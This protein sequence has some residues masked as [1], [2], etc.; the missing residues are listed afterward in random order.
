MTDTTTAPPKL[1]P[2][3]FKH[4]FWR[5]HRVLHRLS[6]GR[7]LWTPAAKRG[8]GALRLTTTGRRSGQPRTVIIGYIEDGPNLVT[9]AMNGWDEGHPAWW[10][11]LEADP[12]ATV[13]LAHEQPRPVRARA[14]SGAERDRLWQRWREIDTGLDAYAS[15]RRASAPIVVLAPREGPT[16]E[17]SGSRRQPSP[18]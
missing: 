14:V 13:R 5:V 11:N 6:R 3:W 7:F 12:D 17:V 16:S 9:L 18:T 1:P 2:A 15:S 8:W 4:L 10:L